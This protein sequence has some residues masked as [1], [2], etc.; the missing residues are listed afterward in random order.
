[1]AEARNPPVQTPPPPE[2]ARR[3]PRWRRFALRL[4]AIV[5]AVVAAAFVTLFSVDLG[6]T[7]KQRAEVAG[8]KYLDRPL[9]IGKLS[10]LVAPG[11]FAL[12]DVVIEGLSPTDRPFMKA[13]RITV[14]VPWWTAFTHQLI[15]ESIE[16]TDWTAVIETW[17]DS[18]EFPHGRHNLPR[19]KPEPKKDQKPSRWP[20]T[21]T[22]RKV[23]ASRGSFTFEDH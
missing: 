21:T 18:P 6:P 2:P 11:E 9:H 23:L 4:L 22:L 3:R 7:L 8:S 13:K 20:L 19:F 14:S 12:D 5:V 1:M 16:M 10:A 15:I 17:P